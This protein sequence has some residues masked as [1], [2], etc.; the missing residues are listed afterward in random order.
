[1]R[2]EG[3][4]ELQIE[5]LGDLKVAYRM[6]GSGERV[7]F[8]HGLAQDSRMWACQQ[9]E[10]SDYSTFAYDVRGHGQTTLGDC[11]GT[12][13]QLGSDL[14]SFLER[15]GAASC[16]GFS[17]GG[18]VALWAAARRP[19]LVSDVVAIATSSVVGRVA[20][21]F[22]AKRI[23]LFATSDRTAVRSALLEDTRAQLAN[24]SVDVEKVT[25]LRMEAI[26]D[27]KGYV[28]GARAMA[29][30]H[31]HPL[32]DLLECITSPVLVVS[33]EHDVVC[34]RRASEI[35]L[36]HLPD[37]HFEELPS[38]GHLVTDE[39]PGLV[40]SVISNWMDRMHRK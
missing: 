37:G 35:M 13:T 31:E 16:V 40:T 17:L 4:T 23:A 24:P 12:L 14:I 36:E 2:A 25:N 33:G 9:Q 10:L 21:A 20:A 18:T 39:N 11:D 26:G 22:L 34:P 15:V 3:I 29:A 7:V 1:M 5:R 6:A 27:G 19:D 32:N 38:V 30:I 28:N 8:I